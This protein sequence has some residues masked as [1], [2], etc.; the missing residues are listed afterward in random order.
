MIHPEVGYAA[1]SVGAA[2]R[3]QR[4]REAQYRHGAGRLGEAAAGHSCAHGATAGDEWQSAQLVRAQVVNHRRPGGVELACRS[5]SASSRD[6]VGLLDERANADLL[7]ARY[8]GHRDQI[9]RRHSS[10]G[11]VTEDE[12]GPWLSGGMH[13]HLRLPVRGVHF[14][15]RHVCDTGSRRS[16]KPRKGLCSRGHA[17]TKEGTMRGRLAIA[18]VGCLLAAAVAPLGASGTGKPGNSC[19]PGFNLGSKTADEFLALERTQ[20]WLI[21]VRLS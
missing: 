16:L 15:H 2:R 1:R 3:L 7:R 8:A 9:W 5:G 10:G 20:V 6:T 13:V 17:A 12:R 18:T 4:K 21:R 19:P 14:E 11:T